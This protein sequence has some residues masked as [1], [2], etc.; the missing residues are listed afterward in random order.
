LN[1]VSSA[2]LDVVPGRLV[3][4][5]WLNERG[6]I[7][8]DVT[9][10]RIAYD[11][12]LVVN[13]AASQMKDLHWL[14]AHAEQFD[15]D[16]EDITDRYAVLGIMGPNS[17]KLLQPLTNSSLANP[18]FQ[19]STSQLLT[20]AGMPVRAT[21]ITYVGEL[22]WELYIEKQYA[23]S[24]YTALAANNPQHAGYHALDSLRLE[25]CYR[26]WG[27]DIGD[28]DTPLEAGL[29]FTIDWQKQDPNIALP[30]L[31]R[32]RSEGLK[33]RMLAFRLSDPQALLYHDE[34]IWRDG[35]PV[36]HITSGAYAHTLGCAIGLGYVLSDEPTSLANLC[37]A[38]YEIE[39]ADQRVPATATSR[40]FVDPDNQHMHL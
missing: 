22:G 37:K 12:Y 3:Y 11:E 38:S 1:Y 7:E 29:G 16:V 39:I 9:I 25:K 23:Q 19:F 5:Q 28:E 21:R 31:R 14:T 10:T 13:A 24:V 33:K 15:V 2:N 36:G 18:D 20:L 17:R 32:Q 8:A 35:A 26:H 4:C 30:A 27:H 40:A 6:G 34:P